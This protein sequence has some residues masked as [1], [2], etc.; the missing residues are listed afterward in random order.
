[1]E[2]WF[3]G[4]RVCALDLSLHPGV[5]KCSA[6]FLTGLKLFCDC[7]RITYGGFQGMQW[8]C[9]GNVNEMLCQYECLTVTCQHSRSQ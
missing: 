9:A 3:V 7:T 4:E 2:N 5:P 1:M 8:M 6:Y